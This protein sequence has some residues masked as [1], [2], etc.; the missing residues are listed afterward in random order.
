MTPETPIV[1]AVAWFAAIP[2][3]ILLREIVP[4]LVFKK[5]SNNRR[6]NSD[7]SNR[8]AKVLEDHAVHQSSMAKSLEVT[9]ATTLELARSMDLTAAKIAELHS[10]HG[11]DSSGR[12]TW[13]GMDKI[14]QEVDE[15]KKIVTKICN[16]IG[17]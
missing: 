1:E 4:Q 9:A 6:K 10:W 7:S 16:K 2:V 3:A 14:E 15:V 5:N 8:I 12:Q 11:P 17:G 13:K